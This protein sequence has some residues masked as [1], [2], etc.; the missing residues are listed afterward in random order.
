MKVR[1]S[2]ETRSLAE[3]RVLDS[4]VRLTEGESRF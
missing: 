1:L 4:L 3:R 2:D